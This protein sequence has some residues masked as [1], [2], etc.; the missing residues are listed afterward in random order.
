MSS[1][2]QLLGVTPASIQRL[3]VNNTAADQTVTI[4]PVD[5]AKTVVLITPSLG[6]YADNQQLYSA[7][8]N[9]ATTVVISKGNSGTQGP[10]KQGIEVIDFGDMVRNVQR[11][12]VNENTKAASISTV[13]PSKCMVIVQV[14]YDNWDSGQPSDNTYTLSAS[15]LTFSVAFNSSKRYWQIVEFW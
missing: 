6:A 10:G 2:Q 7:I 8:L 5:P 14:A 4:A 12:V 9:S 3:Q 11:G 13:N 15:S 1:Y